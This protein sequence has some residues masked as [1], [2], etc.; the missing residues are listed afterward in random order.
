[1]IKK[2]KAILTAVLTFSLIG[3]L[4]SGC[5]EKNIETTV[6][7]DSNNTAINISYP[8]KTDVKLKMWMS[9]H[10]NLASQVKNFGDSEIG[11]ELE[12][13]TGIKVEYSHPAQGQEKEQLNLMLAS[14]DLPDIIEWDWF[15]GFSGGPEKAINDGY[16]IKLNDI[17]NKYAPNF[18]KVLSAHPDWDKMIRT[19]SG[20]YYGFAFFR[21][22]PSLTVFQGPIVRK[23]WLDELGLSIPETVDDWTIMLKA[24]KD[25]KGAIAPL[26]YLKGYIDQGA[27]SGPYGIK[28]GLYMNNGK[29]KYGQIEQEFKNYLSLMRQWYADGLLDKNIAAVDQKAID[30]SI[31]NN[32]T[33]ATVNNTGGG[34]GRWVP[35]LAKDPKAK[36]VGAPYPTLK[37]GDTPEFGQ[38]D[39]PFNANQYTITKLCKNPEI[40][41]RYLDYGYSSEGEL[42]F[43][44]GI[45][46]ISY[47]M[48]NNYPKYTDLIMNNP[49]KLSPAII[50]T[51][52]IRANYN[53]PMV[54]RKE[55][56]EQ[57]A[58]LPEQKE[59]I[60]I[61]MK[62]NVDK[63]L[64]PKA[65]FT[66][67]ESQ[68]AANIVNQLDTYNDEMFMKFIMGIEP[69]DNFNKYVEQLKKLGVE[70]YIQLNQAAVDRYNKR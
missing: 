23:D 56:I 31:I 3:T 63:H 55:Y 57:Y 62:T 70:K 50:M 20:T 32:K 29:V 60:S 16:I 44:F 9:L 65:T 41:A 11:K 28:P 53:G 45:E 47:K 42:L 12:K 66:P 18:K 64:M 33:G 69:I 61:W 13:K 14:N 36:L 37:K 22:D 40:A 39:I 68:E 59:A 49:D 5:K 52:Y 4:L 24:F 21:G 2:S 48:E 34:I 38:K 7:T 10:G 25:K 46:G 26:S 51:Q 19:D 54:Q 35:L 1:M 30:A 15:S 27:F 43:N 58:A 67:D 17:F 8:I 6:E